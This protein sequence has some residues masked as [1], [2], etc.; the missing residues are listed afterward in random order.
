MGLVLNVFSV[1]FLLF[2]FVMVS[3]QDDMYSRIRWLMRSQTF[4]PTVPHPSA[5]Q[6]NW[7]IL[8][9]GVV[10]IFSIGYYVAVGRH[11]Y[12]GPVTYVRKGV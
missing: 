5:E 10:V 4:F 12:A 11:R 2:T 3:V 6:M 8:V 1:L 7:N 9:F